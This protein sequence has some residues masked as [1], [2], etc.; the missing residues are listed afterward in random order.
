MAC[1]SGCGEPEESCLSWSRHSRVEWSGVKNLK[2]DT[3]MKRIQLYAVDVTL[4]P[5]TANSGLIR[6]EYRKQVRHVDRRQ[7]LPNN[8]KTFSSRT[9]ILGK[10]GFS[11]GR[12]YYEV[13]V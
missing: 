10:K 13:T 4:D 12:F 3:E 2:C 6:S 1:R 7:T 8:P 11:S 5:D 9:G